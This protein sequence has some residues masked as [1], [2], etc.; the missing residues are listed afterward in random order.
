MI[1]A[2]GDWYSTLQTQIVIGTDLF[3]IKGGVWING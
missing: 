3:Q 1:M 2:G